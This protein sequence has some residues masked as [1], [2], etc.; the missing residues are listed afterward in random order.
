MSHLLIDFTKHVL[1]IL[2]MLHAKVKQNTPHYFSSCVEWV[3][4]HGLSIKVIYN[5]IKLF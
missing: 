5:T 4:P 2:W 3:M 1:V